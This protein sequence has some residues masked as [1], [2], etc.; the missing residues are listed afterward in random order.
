MGSLIKPGDPVLQGPIQILPV[1]R[2]CE[3]VIQIVQDCDGAVVFQRIFNN[4]KSGGVDE[5]LQL[6]IL[7]VLPPVFR[8]EVLFHVTFKTHGI[9]FGVEGGPLVPTFKSRIVLLATI[10]ISP[11]SLL[12]RNEHLP[13]W[14]IEA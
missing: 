8:Q 13:K 11:G 5:V 7:S 6:G 14:N 2:A 4:V 3:E 10:L 12:K 1:L 9:H